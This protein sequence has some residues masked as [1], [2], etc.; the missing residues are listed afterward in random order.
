MC[1]M[2]CVHIPEIARKTNKPILLVT[3]PVPRDKT[4]SPASPTMKAYSAEAIRLYS[5]VPGI[6]TC[7][8]YKHQQCDRSAGESVRTV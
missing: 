8:D 3:K 2:I 4:P 7:S 1:K 6:F 5:G